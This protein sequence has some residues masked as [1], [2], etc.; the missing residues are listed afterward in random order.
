MFF[1]LILSAQ[2]KFSS[3]TIAFKYTSDSLIIDQRQFEQTHTLIKPEP[4]CFACYEI[5]GFL[6]PYKGGTK[7]IQTHRLMTLLE[8]RKM[9]KLLSLWI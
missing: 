5:I 2:C 7:S 6:W 1:N 3:V 4:L 8:E 9:S